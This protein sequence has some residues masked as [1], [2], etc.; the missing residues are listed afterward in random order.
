MFNLRLFK[1][2]LPSEKSTPD[3]GNLFLVSAYGI[4]QSIDLAQIR[5]AIDY[6][7]MGYRCLR[8]PPEV[9]TEILF[10]TTPTDAHDPTSHQDILIFR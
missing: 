8:L 9:A 3:G 6:E 7:A 1:H 10:L 4:A 2:Q 5:L